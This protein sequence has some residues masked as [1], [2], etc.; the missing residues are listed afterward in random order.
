MR[1]RG[2]LGAVA[3][4]LSAAAVAGCGLSFGGANATATKAEPPP[5]RATVGQGP[6]HP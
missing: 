2:S 5:I 6:A 3:V 1:R 4:V